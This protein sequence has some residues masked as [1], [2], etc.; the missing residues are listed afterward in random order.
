MRHNKFILHFFILFVFLISITAISAADLNDTGSIDILNDN[1]GNSF[2]DL[3]SVIQIENS[4]FTFER[5][6]GFNS[7]IDKS[8]SSGINVTKDNFVINGFVEILFDFCKNFLKIYFYFY[9][10]LKSIKII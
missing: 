1:G 9:F 6:Y 5:D 7:E 2:N 3:N 8:Y 10:Y 4:S